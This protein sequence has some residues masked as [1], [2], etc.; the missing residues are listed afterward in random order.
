[1]QF[2]AVVDVRK[3]CEMTDD[4]GNIKTNAHITQVR[5][6]ERLADEWRNYAN[7]LGISMNSVICI[8]LDEW[9]RRVEH[10]RQHH[11]A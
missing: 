6:S 8:A 11:D 10:S 4:E 9:L 2:P 5:M 7:K 3:G 1:M